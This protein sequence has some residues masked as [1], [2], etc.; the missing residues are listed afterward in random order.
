MILIGATTENPYFEVNGALISRSSIFELKPLEKEDIKKLLVRAVEDTEKGMGSFHAQIDP[1]ALEFLAD[2][3]GGDARNALNA[4][5]LGILTTDRSSDGIIHLT[6][7][8]ASE[9]IQKRVVNYDKKGITIMISFLPLLKVCGGQTRMQ[10]SFIL[11]K[12]CMREKM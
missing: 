7:E 1:D 6:L 4:V 3:S 2:V 9:C 10:Q 8:V 12:C 11:Q 5:E